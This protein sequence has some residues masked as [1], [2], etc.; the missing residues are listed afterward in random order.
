MAN[1][2][3]LLTK[4]IN[5]IVDVSVGKYMQGVQLNVKR[6]Y[7]AIALESP[8]LT[9]YYASNHSLVIKNAQGQFKTQGARLSPGIKESEVPLFYNDNV[10][11]RM[12]QELEKVPQIALGDT[13]EINNIVDY[14][15]DVERKH[16]VYSSIAP[17]FGFTP[18]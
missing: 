6:A 18:K 5:D 14:A 7:T 3:S 17:S 16:A 4:Q 13:I 1:L 11:V 9:G 2:A 8:V 15:D 12:S 10:E